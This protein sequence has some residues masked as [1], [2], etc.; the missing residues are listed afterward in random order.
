MRVLVN[1]VEEGE[2]VVFKGADTDGIKLTFLEDDGT[3]IDITGGTVSLEVH[4][5]KI[6]GTPVTTLTGSLS[7]PIGGHGTLDIPLA[8]ATFGPGTFY[9]FGKLVDG[10]DT[11]YGALPTKL[12]VK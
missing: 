7:V 1:G 9:A 4:S 11:R 3:P 6:R 10:G 12:T 5:G 2:L 8:S